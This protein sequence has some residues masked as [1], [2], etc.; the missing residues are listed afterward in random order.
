M[1]RINTNEQIKHYPPEYLAK[2]VLFEVY[3][4]FLGFKVHELEP[5]RGIDW[6]QYTLALDQIDAPNSNEFA[7][8]NE[9]VNKV[10]S[11]NKELRTLFATAVLCLKTAEVDKFNEIIE[12]LAEKLVELSP[13]Q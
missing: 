8:F 6:L 4:S 2:R 12:K 13:E 11:E 7:E 10:F 3:Y 9:F 5:I 1:S